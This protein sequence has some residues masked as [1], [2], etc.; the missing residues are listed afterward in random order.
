MGVRPAGRV[1]AAAP[2][3]PV[4]APPRACDDEADPPARG[5]EEDVRVAMVLTVAAAGPRGRERR[6]T[7]VSG[8]AGARASRTGARALRT[9]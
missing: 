5:V 6:R 8:R 9:R 2:R 1:E 7:C 3:V 4:R